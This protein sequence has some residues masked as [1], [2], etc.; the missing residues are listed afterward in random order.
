MF[1]A[2]ILQ[3]CRSSAS[4]FKN[5][6][7]RTHISQYHM[8]INNGQS[9]ITVLGPQCMTHR[10]KRSSMLLS[11]VRTMAGHS[12][13]ANIKHTK[14]ARDNQRASFMA[15]LAHRAMNA[16]REGGGADPTK[17]KQ[18]SKIIEQARQ[19]DIPNK[20][21]EELLK[22]LSS[23][24]D[25]ASALL[26]EATG[27]GG[28]ALVIEA[29]AEKPK[30]A[31]QEI[32]SYIKKLGGRV[33]GAMHCFERKGVITV[34]LP[35]DVTDD[36]VDMDKFL[37]VAIEVG[38]EDVAFGKEDNRLTL[39]FLTD[40]KE[41]HSVKVQLEGRQLPVE[42]CEYQYIPTMMVSLN[43]VEMETVS[44]LVEKINSHPDV[45]NIYDNI[46]ASSNS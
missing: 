46:A 9:G 44:K 41:L 25:A 21:I 40:V 10:S 32:E 11:I 33:G 12:H 28:S 39:Q 4:K 5:L 8:D 7:R 23:S 1:P 34:V 24:S 22:K 37:E 35:D 2:T 17:N 19:N 20:R 18:L 16:V 3:L 30:K 42:S 43:P 15:K 29:L 31:M 14:E 36:K 38:A 45:T 26:L 13:W 6:V 27:P